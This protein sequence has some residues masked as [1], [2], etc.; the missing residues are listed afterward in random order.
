MGIGTKE[1]NGDWTK[2]KIILDFQC[3]AVYFSDE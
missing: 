1:I 2:V 3:G